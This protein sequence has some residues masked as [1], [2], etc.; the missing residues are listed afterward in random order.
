MKKI[1]VVYPL[2]NPASYYKKLDVESETYDL[3]IC[4]Y[5]DNNLPVDHSV[6]DFRTDGLKL[7]TCL[8]GLSQF[9]LDRVKEYDY[10]MLMDEDI[11]IDPWDMARLAELADEYNTVICQPAVCHGIAD[12]PILVQDH[13]YLLRYTSFIEM[14]APVFRTDFFL[15]Q[16]V[17]L[18]G[19]NDTGMGIDYVWSKLAMNERGRLAVI[20]DVAVDHGFWD[21][22]V[23]TCTLQRG[24]TDQTSRKDSDTNKKLQDMKPQEEYAELQRQYGIASPGQSDRVIGFEPHPA[25]QFADTNLEGH[26]NYNIVQADVTSEGI[27]AVIRVK[28]E[29]MHIKQ[30]LGSIVQFFDKIIVVLNNPTD[31]TGEIVRDMPHE[32]VTVLEYPFDIHPPAS[33]AHKH[34]AHDSVH[35]LAYFYNW[36]FSHVTTS[37]AC[38]WDGDMIA[39]TH[40]ARLNRRTTLDYDTTHFS[41][42]DMINS[43]EQ[44]T[45]A[46]FVASEPR[47]FR[48]R[49]DIY[50]AK[51]LLY[52]FLVVDRSLVSE[53]SVD[54]IL[55]GHMKPEKM[56]LINATDNQ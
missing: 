7:K 12:H 45:G 48:K 27:T 11:D 1:L 28:N 4:R 36:C 19:I 15:A 8:D 51:S 23:V 52:E 31:R 2:G 26:E 5:K 13:G 14:A 37:H 10:V 33:D 54:H 42:K 29:E 50:Y 55:Y 46:P 40:L 47:I 34:S 39:T 3:L 56:R 38:K 17:D 41:G 35:N 24:M 18:L 21:T 20:D 30:C 22:D 25:R 16:V 53:G 43:L 9:G 44:Y 6:G 49:S 32:K